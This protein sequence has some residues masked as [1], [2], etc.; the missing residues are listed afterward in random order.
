MTE[1][2]FFEICKELDLGN[3]LEDAKR[4]YGGFMHK[5]Y[6]I[7]T[8]KKEYA[9][10]MLNPEIMKRTSVFEN[11]NIAETLEYK[12]QEE[13][14][15]IVPS[16][17]FKGNKMQCIDGQYF[18]VFD[19]I[20]GKALHSNEI[21]KEHCKTIGEILAKIHKLDYKDKEYVCERLQ[22]DWDYYINSSFEKCPQITDI[23][24]VNRDLLY[25]SQEKANK[26]FLNVPS[27]ECICNG[28]MDSKNVLW[29][30]NK[31]RII[32]LECLNYDNPYIE[33]FQLALCW[34][35]YEECNLDY[36]LLKSFIKSY[37][38]EVGVID[39]DWNVLYHA[40][41]GRLGWLEYNIKRALMLECEDEEE[42]Q[43]GIKEVFDTVDHV[44][45]YEKIK[46]P[47]LEKLHCLDMEN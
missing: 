17:M 20:K 7:K 42:R 9:I 40:N 27:G 38:N 43:L 47:L 33:L 2:V 18:Y 15:P 39:V 34:S 46:K 11:L 14:I 3:V 36:D 41:V 21:R 26:A 28:D 8:D 24:K 22:I 4:V 32:D 19:W 10:K 23:L 44:I 6:Y 13:G 12:L 25:Y 35:G 30:D 37:K 16:L 45:Y 31:P 1:N 5:M 29:I